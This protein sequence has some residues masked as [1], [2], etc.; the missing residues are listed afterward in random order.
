MSNTSFG[1]PLNVG[2]YAFLQEAL[3]GA[4]G[5][6]NGNH[7]VK[8]GRESNVKYTKRQELAW[9]VNHLRPACERFVGYLSKKSVERDLTHPLLEAFADNCDWRGNSIDVFLQN[10]FIEAKAKGVSLLLVDMPNFQPA[11]L[12]QQL[13]RRFIP[14]L[15]SLKPETVRNYVL[16]PQ[17]QLD[18]ITIEVPM[19]VDG[20]YQMVLRHW[21]AMQ[22]SVTL[23]G[24]TVE[25]GE[26]KLGQCP[27][28]IFTE[29]DSFPHVGTFAQIADI[30]KRLYNLASELD[31]ILRAQ[32]FSVLTYQI[33]AEQ[34]GQL[35]VTQLSESIGTSNMLIY[36][37]TQAPSF[38][39]PSSDPANVILKTIETLE[40]KIR[41]IG[42]DINFSKTSNAESG[43]ALNIRFQALNSALFTFARKAEDL[44]RRMFDLCCR[45]LAIQNTTQ[46]SYPKSFEMADLTTELNSLTLY[47]AGGFPPEVI[48]AK[49]KQIINID[50]SNLEKDDLQLLLD[51]VST[52]DDETSLLESRVAVLEA[53]NQGAVDQPAK[54]MSVTDMENM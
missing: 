5:F 33:P 8:F 47:Q 9:Y 13:T 27:V 40:E 17:G 3:D 52:F 24:K 12:E 6:A 46:V 10:F 14:Y 4:G 20:K 54:D 26:H 30:S 39:Q 51:S 11:N 18:S 38:A 45:W 25:G 44:E 34:Q 1:L 16:N 41:T 15:V 21:D 49:Q 23:N 29:G 42:H 48:Q 32:T 22:W 28:L 50:F 35:D 19:F 43:T 36:G 53:N 2:R 7:I 31:E 37:G